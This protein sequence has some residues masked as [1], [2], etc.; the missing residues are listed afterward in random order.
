MD[1][2]LADQVWSVLQD[3]DAGLAPMV[4][5]LSGR[6]RQFAINLRQIELAAEAYMDKLSEEERTQ[7]RKARRVEEARIRKL[8][9]PTVQARVRMHRK[10]KQQGWAKLLP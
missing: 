10:L 8:T 9:G 6:D 3:E 1:G 2:P 7:I 5:D 4:G